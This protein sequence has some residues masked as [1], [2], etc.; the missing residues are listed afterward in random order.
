MTDMHDLLRECVQ[1]FGETPRTPS[2]WD[3]LTYLRVPK[4]FWLK[5]Y[6][7]DD[8]HKIF[9]N[10][11]H[12]FSDGIVVWGHVVQA[13]QMMFDPGEHDC[14]GEV[15]YS[16]DDRETIDALDLQTIAHSLF[17]L[18]GQTPNDGELL[19]IADYL[20]DETVRVF[21]LSVPAK[22]SP[23]FHCQISTTLFVRK[24]L[25]DHRLRRSLLPLLVSPRE[26]NVATS[27]P[28]RYWPDDLVEWWME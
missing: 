25:P 3:R 1:R 21:G 11:R 9:P 16:I 20:T 14:P 10:L 15:V 8:L 23:Q 26:P 28:A 27:L 12:A 13:N 24:H 5:E 18:K 6:P 4:P 22:I 17:E 7:N 2:L 19:P